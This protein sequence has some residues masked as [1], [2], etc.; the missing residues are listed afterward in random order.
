MDIHFIYLGYMYRSGFAGL[1]GK[2]IVTLLRKYQ[3]V[4]QRDY[5][6]TFIPEMLEFAN[7]S[8]SYRCVV[9]L[10]D[11]SHFGSCVV[12]SHCGFDLDFY[13]VERLLIY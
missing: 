9:N 7:F 12:V 5:H 1:F 3:A 13:N 10:L 8:L 4:F 6:F 2:Y 11:C